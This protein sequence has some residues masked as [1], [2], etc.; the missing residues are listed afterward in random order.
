M[1]HIILMIRA[2]K[3]E[4]LVM[5]DNYTE[6]AG[7]SGKVRCQLKFGLGIDRPIIKYYIKIF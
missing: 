5:D 3:R 1:V 2:S 7:H 6:T 4:Y